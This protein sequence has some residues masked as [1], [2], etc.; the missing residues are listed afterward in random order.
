MPTKQDYISDLMRYHNAGLL[1]KEMLD[2][3]I[4]KTDEVPD[5][6]NFETLSSAQKTKIRKARDHMLQTA[7]ILQFALDGTLSA[8]HPCVMNAYRFATRKNPDEY[9]LQNNNIPLAM[10]LNKNEISKRSFNALWRSGY[11]TLESV[12]SLTQQE[13]MSIPNLG[14]RS[15]N[16][17]Q[18][19]LTE[20]GL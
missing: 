19:L 5:E 7:G 13:L 17:V 2:I 18:N 11:R 20:Y 10:L 8:S 1:S 3:L 12:A 6:N 15:L 9:L 14:K 16:E 4:A